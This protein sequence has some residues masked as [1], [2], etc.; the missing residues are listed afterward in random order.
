MM[1]HLSVSLKDLEDAAHLGTLT[2]QMLEQYLASS[3][4][5]IND[6]HG[7]GEMQLMLVSVFG[8]LE[9]VEW[10]LA[11]GAD[12]FH[13]ESYSASTALMYTSRSRTGDALGCV[14]ALLQ[15]GAVVDDVDKWGWTALH[16]AICNQ[17]RDEAFVL[18]KAGAKLDGVLVDNYHLKS[19]PDWAVS[20][21]Q[22]LHLAQKRASQTACT[23]LVL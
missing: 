10:L 22:S 8:F 17:N 16:Q 5:S 21:S 14:E 7:V 18:M 19:I 15:H 4:A 1:E 9:C 12:H 23:L 20:M 11:K 13:R 6:T 3:S 2:V